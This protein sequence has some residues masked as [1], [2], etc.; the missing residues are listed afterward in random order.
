MNRPGDEWGARLRARGDIRGGCIGSARTADT[1]KCGG[2]VP[3]DR[4]A[5]PHPRRF[6]RPIERIQLAQIRPRG[7]QGVAAIAGA[8][9]SIQDIFRDYRVGGLPAMNGLAR[10]RG[11]GEDAVQGGK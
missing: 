3:Q 11:R 8:G 4:K 2:K 6:A 7:I 9:K 10:V 1:D 5:M